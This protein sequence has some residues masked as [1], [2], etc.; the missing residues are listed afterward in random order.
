MKKLHPWIVTHTH[1]YGEDSII[2]L[3]EGMPDAIDLAI[4]ANNGTYEPNRCDEWIDVNPLPD[5]I[6]KFLDHD[7]MTEYLNEIYPEGQLGR[8]YTII[9]LASPRDRERYRRGLDTR[10]TQNLD[11]FNLRD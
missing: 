6:T 2:I 4:S 9:P 11:R 8:E 3:C 1:C 7:K 5:F 10:E